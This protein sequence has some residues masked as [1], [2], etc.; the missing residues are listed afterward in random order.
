MGWKC[1]YTPSAVA[2]HVRRVTPER[3]ESLPHVI[4]WHS[5]KNRFLMRG[6]NAS[7]LAVLALFW[8]VVWRD[9]MVFGYALL[10]D[11][12]MLSAIV[13]PLKHLSPA[14]ARKRRDHSG[15]SQ[16]VR[17]RLALVVQRHAA[18]D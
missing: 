12:R 11:W 13:Y 15:A 2:W 6:K 3:R 17:P 1:L 7:W 4:N 9:L 14:F 5:V 8:P 18:R 10:R 16:R